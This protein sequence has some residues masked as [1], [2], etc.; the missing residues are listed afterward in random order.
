M[1]HESVISGIFPFF[2]MFTILSTVWSGN[3]WAILAVM[4]LIQAV[5]LLKGIFAAIIRGSSVMIFMSLYSCL[6]VT[7]LLPGKIFAITTIRNKSWG[8]SGRKVLFCNYNAVMPV[9]VWAL[10]IIAGMLKTLA[11]NKYERRDEAKYLGCGVLFYIAY[12]VSMTTLFKCSVQSTMKKKADWSVEGSS[13]G[14]LPSGSAEEISSGSAEDLSSSGSQSGS[15]DDDDMGHPVKLNALN[16]GALKGVLPGR[17]EITRTYTT[18]V[19]ETSMFSDSY[20]RS[21][22][23]SNQ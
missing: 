8:T 9:S 22:T 4:I 16:L 13:E 15:S 6:Y 2:V 5:G 3:L 19:E 11:L 7:S 21:S 18:S 17:E 23:L 20:L 12:W 14:S 1:V 10:F